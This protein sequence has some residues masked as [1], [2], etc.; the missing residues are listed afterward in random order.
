M[1]ETASPLSFLQSLLRFDTTNPPGAERDCI[2]WIA[3]QLEQAGIDYVLYGRTADRPNLVARLAG[4][5]NAPPLLL[6]GHVDV[7]P[8]SGQSWSHPPFSADIADGCVWG[9]GALDMKGAVA[10]M[11]SAI[12][13]IK[14]GQAKP[15]GD[16]ILAVV[17]DEEAGGLEGAGYLVDNHAELFDG[18]RHALGELGGFTQHIAGRRFYPIMVAEKQ[19][20]RVVLRVRGESGHASVPI[21]GGAVAR[22]ARVLTALDRRRL[23]VHVTPVARLMIDTMADHLPRA[24]SLVMWGLLRPAIADRVLPLLGPLAPNL[25]ALLRNTAVPTIVEAGS[26][27][28]V[29]PGEAM[30]TLDGRILPGQTVDGFV[31]ELRA[32][33]GDE[34]EIETHPGPAAPGAPDMSQFEMLGGILRDA[35]PGSIPMPML[36]PGVTD[37][38]HFSRLGIQTY[39]FTPMILPPELPFTRLIHAADE[40]IPV[41][42]LEFGTRAM[43]EAIVRYSG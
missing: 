14:G 32:V 13:R 19:T 21:Y 23:P 7:V 33:V 22:L 8:T 11:L 31:R 34:I 17:S 18:V 25:S 28:N 29:I 37:A 39:G 30:V 35:D 16:V 2:A 24:Q 15:N 10:M 4:I 6:Y 27:I 12:L 3:D 40:R 1:A 9:R 5:G 36:L 42:A 41:D 20:C 38:R 26:K 43:L